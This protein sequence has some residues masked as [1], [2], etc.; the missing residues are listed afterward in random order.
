MYD[1]EYWMA[2]QRSDATLPGYLIVS[3]KELEAR[4]LEDLSIGAL[5]E[6]GYVL[7]VVTQALRTSFEPEHVY[8]CRFGMS[9]GFTVHFHV[10]PIYSWAKEAYR[11]MAVGDLVRYP[12]F[13]DG[14]S[15]TLFASEEF[16]RGRAPCAVPEPSVAKVTH[17]LRKA[18]SREAA[19]QA[20]GTDR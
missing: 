8:V 3:A 11:R 6:L 4:E 19:Q 5:G 7:K 12:S 9:P 13:T 20:A 1:T 15:L 2:S 16:T 10:I 18:L 17:T 14:A